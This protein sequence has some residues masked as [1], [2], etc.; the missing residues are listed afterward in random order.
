MADTDTIATVPILVDVVSTGIN[1]VQ[2]DNTVVSAVRY[3]S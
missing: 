2:V 1:K 3:P